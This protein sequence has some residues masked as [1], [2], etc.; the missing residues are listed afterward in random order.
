MFLKI[1]NLAKQTFLR[2]LFKE[3]TPVFYVD[4]ADSSTS[5]TDLRT[6]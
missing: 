2:S 4:T 6:K 5:F 3:F 1:R